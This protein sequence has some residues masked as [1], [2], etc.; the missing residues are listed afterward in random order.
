MFRGVGVP[1]DAFAALSQRLFARNAQ[2]S[3]WC[4]VRPGTAEALEALRGRGLRLGIVSNA[5][6]RVDGLLGDVGLLPYFEVVVDS[7]AVGFEK[8]DPRIFHAA[9]EMMG[10]AAKDAAYVGDVYEID[11]AGARA[12]GMRPVLLDP[13]DRF[14][15]LDCER[16]RAL[17]EL[18]ALLEGA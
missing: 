17:G 6:G 11:V 2:R 4:G 1:A 13:L 12:A 9:L 16:I 14:G 8:P 5:D 15:A 7:K 3:L 10:V 18:P